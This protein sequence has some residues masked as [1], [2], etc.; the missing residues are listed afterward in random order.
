MS[1]CGGGSGTTVS[2]EQAVASAPASVTLGAMRSNYKNRFLVGAAIRHDHL[3]AA[4]ASALIKSQFSVVVAENVMKP[5]VISVSEGVY[6]FSEG[7][8]MVVFA[9]AN[10]IKLRGH[11]LVWHNQAAPW[12]F[13]DKPGKAVLLA[14]MKCYINDV[15]TH[16]K[17][18]VFAWDVVNEAFIGNGDGSPQLGATG[19]RDSNWL[20]GFGRTESGG[21]EFIAEAFKTARAA[22]PSALL[23]YNDYSTEDPKKSGLILKLIDD[24]KKQGVP[25]DGIGHQAHFSI[26]YPENWNALEQIIKNIAA[27]GLTN[28]ITELDISLNRSFDGNEVTLPFPADRLAE[29]AAKYRGLFDMLIRNQEKVS[30]VLV[31][32]LKDSE[33][34][35]NTYP[36]VRQDG[37]LLFD[38]ALQPKSAYQAV[39]DVAPL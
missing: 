19:W 3:T 37:P 18:E 22:D 27:K 35:L 21:M 16:F 12:M 30:A 29:Q 1:A 17:G 23:F 28:Y 34:W 14:R 13:A 8:K 25:I 24:L 26:A 31:W 32:G 39:M 11:T 10:N 5:S 4:D 36:I 15:V 6:D 2:S 7:D 38:S 9:K 20:Q 33:S